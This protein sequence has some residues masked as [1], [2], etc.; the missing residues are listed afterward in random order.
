MRTWERSPSGCGPVG[1]PSIRQVHRLLCTLISTVLFPHEA[2]PLGGGASGES[3][4]HRRQ[5]SASKITVFISW[6]QRWWGSCESL[7]VRL[8][9]SGSRK[10]PKSGLLTP[11]SC[12]SPHPRRL[13][14]RQPNSNTCASRSL[15]LSWPISAHPSSTIPCTAPSCRR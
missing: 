2:K 12:P 1:V 7:A 11:L 9:T 5:A 6:G 4:S 13:R 8:R 10:L 3:Q 14:C 15:M